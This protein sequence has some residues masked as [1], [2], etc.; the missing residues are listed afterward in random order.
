M[1]VPFESGFWVAKVLLQRIQRTLEYIE[2][3]EIR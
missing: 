1:V 2:L 3:E